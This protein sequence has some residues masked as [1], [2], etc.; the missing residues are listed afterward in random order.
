MK[1]TQT[2][3]PEVYLLE[4]N[5]FGDDRGYF[6]EVFRQDIFSKEINDRVI[7]C[8]DNESK[9]TR[10]I[11][12]GLHY[13]LPPYAQSKLVRVVQGEV[14]DVAVDIRAGSKTY[15]QHVSVILNDKN[16][17]QLFIPRGF[18][19][20]FAVL[21]DEAIFCYKVDNYYSSENDRGI[22]YN[23]PDLNIDWMLEESSIVLSDKDKNLMSFNDADKFDSGQNL[24]E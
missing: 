24:Y 3:I 7:F 10:G 6:S 5:V 20:G 9:S 11:L 15:G 18:A 13:Q 16:K 23:D 19:H 17:K 2:K 21:S 8:Q 12:R 4:P 1:I 14:L 22:V